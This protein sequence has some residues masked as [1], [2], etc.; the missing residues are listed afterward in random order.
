MV[1]AESLHDRAPDRVRDV[2]DVRL[3][4][5]TAYVALLRTAAAALGARLDLTL[6][7]IQDL[8][9]AVD[10]ACAMLLPQAISDSQLTCEFELEDNTMRVCVAVSTA[11]GQL[12]ARN[13]FAWT[14]LTA[15]AGDVQADLSDDGT[16]SITLYKQRALDA[17]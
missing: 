1:P 7:D 16:L 8:R 3:P 5:D 6:D 9:I 12:P 2:V 17:T 4:A 15:L 10:E 13:T 11:G 14:V